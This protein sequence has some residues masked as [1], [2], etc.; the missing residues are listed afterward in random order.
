MRNLFLNLITAG[1]LLMSVSCLAKEQAIVPKNDSSPTPLSQSQQADISWPSDPTEFATD[2]NVGLKRE[3]TN[4]ERAQQYRLARPSDR[5]LSPAAITRVN[6]NNPNQVIPFL[7]WWG[8]RGFT[9]NDS[10]DVLVAI[11]V[12]PS[13][14]DHNRYG[15]VVLASPASERGAYKVYWVA[16]EEDMESHLISPASGSIFIECFRRD[17]SE[18]TKQ[19][20][21]DRKSKQFR[22][23]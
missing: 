1:L 4:F 9:S 17:G 21:W 2:D 19:L 10:K 12:D 15:L 8:V 22:L 23:I 16:R 11:V 7:T 18:Q 20:A 3:W 6:T 13:R 14:S 5:R